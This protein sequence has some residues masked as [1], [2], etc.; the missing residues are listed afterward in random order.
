VPVQVG[1][2][3]VFRLLALR[4]PEPAPV[5]A[6]GAE[7]P[8]KRSLETAI[9][10]HGGDGLGDVGDW[11][12][13]E[14]TPIA[15]PAAKLI[16]ATARRRSGV[17]TVVAL[18][19][20]T[21]LALT[22]DADA[23]ALAH[24]RRLVVMGGAVDVPGNT[25]PTTEF[26]AHVDPEAAARVFTAGLPL[27]LVP[28]DA[29]RQAVLTHAELERSLVTRPG[30]VAERVAAITRR[31]FAANPGGLHMHDPLAVAAAIDPTL[32]EWEPVRIA[33]G[34]EGET[35]RI[36]GPANCRVARRVDRARFIATLLERLC[37]ASS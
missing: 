14:I 13:V 24:V 32:I 6:I 34:A 10:Y 12:P 26:N 31:A 16:A 20:L 37:P 8:L 19:P 30:P 7:R 35:R 17:L 29:T 33:I 23:T 15:E 4:R 2:T 5:V 1:T 22:L 11:P 36:P 27:E 18:G 9:R 21:N 3:N 28:L 25:T